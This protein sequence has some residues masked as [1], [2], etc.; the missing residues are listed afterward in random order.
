MFQTAYPNDC[1]QQG[2]NPDARFQ[3]ALEFGGLKL[4]VVDAQ[5]NDLEASIEVDG[6]ALG[7]SLKTHKL[8]VCT[9]RITVKVNGKSTVVPI[10]LTTDRTVTKTLVVA[11][12]SAAKKRVNPTRRTPVKLAFV[13]IPA[14]QFRMGSP[15]SEIHRGLDETR[16]KVSLENDFLMSKHE[17]TQYEYRAL[18]GMNPSTFK[19]CAS[20]PVESV[21]WLDAIR[22]ANQ[23]SAQDGLPSCYSNTGAVIGGSSVYACKGYRL[24]TEA[25]WEYAARAGSNAAQYGGQ[26]V[27][28]HGGNSW[29][30]S[31]PVG[32]KSPNRFGLFDMLGNVKEWCHDGYALYP[33]GRR[34]NPH[35]NKNVFKTRII[36]GGSWLD[37]W[38]FI[39]VARREQFKANY[40]SRILGFRLVRTV[41]KTPRK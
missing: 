33:G 26:H 2:Q 34:V 1:G 20:C 27:A 31:H 23:L 22:F 11:N 37:A 8:P 40:T 17:V 29:L 21:S 41:H 4:A 30:K 19:S 7:T 25:E 10:Q 39:R 16:H 18:M 12:R 28:W 9:R 36:R 13:R 5:K 14:G 24:P 32:Q 3:P 6:R 15:R 38:P 35:F